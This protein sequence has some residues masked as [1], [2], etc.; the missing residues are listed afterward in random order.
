MIYY[1]MKTKMIFFSVNL[2]GALAYTAL[3]EKS[4]QLLLAHIQDFLK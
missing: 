3:D 1:V 2:G 4:I